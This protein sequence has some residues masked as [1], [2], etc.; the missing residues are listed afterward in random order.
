MGYENSQT[1]KPEGKIKLALNKARIS[2]QIMTLL[3]V[4][5]QRKY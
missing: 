3:N 1:E 4:S 5:F 2:Y